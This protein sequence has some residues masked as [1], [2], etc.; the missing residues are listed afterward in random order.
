MSHSIEK[1]NL[2]F[3]NNFNQPLDDF[4]FPDSLQSITFGEDFNQNIDKVTFPDSLQILTFGYEFN[5]NID[6]V[7]FPNSLQSITFI[8]Y[9]NNTLNDKIKEIKITNL[10]EP[11]TNLPLCLERIIFLKNYYRVNERDENIK[12][13]KIPFGC[14]ITYE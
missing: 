10:V 2:I 1:N 3:D 14:K 9:Q 12:R 13:S 4:K 8:K 7:K 5:Q 11:M 6:K